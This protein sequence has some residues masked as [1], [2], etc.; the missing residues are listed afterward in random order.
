MRRV[1]VTGMGIVSPLGIG[2]ENVWNR[3]LKAESGISGVQS[4]D[5]TDLPCKVAGEVPRGDTASGKFN[6]DDYVPPKDQ[7]KMDT[8]IIMAMGAA[9][10]PAMPRRLM[11]DSVPP[12]TITSASP[13]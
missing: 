11:V 8:F 7:K 13:S 1:V 4:V 10:K 3:L 5:V 6:A 12:A 2:V 9:Q